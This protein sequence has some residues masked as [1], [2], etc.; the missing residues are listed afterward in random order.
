MRSAPR[1]QRRRAEAKR[2]SWCRTCTSTLSGAF[3]VDSASGS[4]DELTFFKTD[5]S[6]DPSPHYYEQSCRNLSATAPGAPGFT[7]LRQ[8]APRF[9]PREWCGFECPGVRKKPSALDVRFFSCPARDCRGPLQSAGPLFPFGREFEI[10]CK[11]P[12]RLLVSGAR[13]RRP[14]QAFSLC[15]FGRLRGGPRIRASSKTEPACSSSR[16]FQRN[17]HAPPRQRASAR[18]W[19]RCA[20]FAFSATLFGSGPG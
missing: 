16:P 10:A 8:G 15:R 17:I 4:F 7:Y 3:F 19:N 9:A 6:C 11:R 13:Q 18:E 14:P 5:S 1:V 2:S 12:L 20:E